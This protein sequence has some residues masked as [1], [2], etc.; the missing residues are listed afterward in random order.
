MVH[1]IDGKCAC[2][3][4]YCH[5]ICLRHSIRLRAVTNRFFSPKRPIYLHAC[6]TYSKLPSNIYTR[7]VTLQQQYGICKVWWLQ[8]C[9]AIPRNRSITGTYQ[10]L[11][12]HL[13][14]TFKLRQLMPCCI[15]YCLG[16]IQGG[17]E[18]SALPPPKFDE[19]RGK[20]PKKGKTEFLI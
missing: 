9:V 11:L 7:S 5:F 15:Q 19:R 1:I 18:I 4:R 2:N 14:S 10:A 13:P 20:E 3:A 6:E 12:M 8:F 17:G 16:R